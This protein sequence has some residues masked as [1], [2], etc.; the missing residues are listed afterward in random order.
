MQSWFTFVLDGEDCRVEKE[1]THRTLSSFLVSLDSCFEHL[2]GHDSWQGGDPVILG[3]IE[4]DRHHFRVVD[5]GLILMPMLAGRQVWTPEGIQNAEPDHPVNLALQ[6]NHLECSRE[7]LGSLKVLLF[8]G[9]YRPDLRRLGQSND[10]F[11]CLVTR[12]TNAP[13]IRESAAQVFESTVQ[14]RHE[15]AQKAERS[16]DESSVWTGR[17]DIFEDRFSR[18]LF[19][20]SERPA[21]NYVD[22]EKRR[23]YRPGTLVELL[24]LKR[25]YPEARFIAG[26][27]DV[28]SQDELAE[29]PNL[30]SLESVP[31]LT[32]FATTE[33]AW[34]I[35]SA[36]PLTEIGELIGRE[37]PPFLK[38]L[39][40]FASRPIRNRATLG[41][42]LASSWTNGQLTPL[43]LAMNARV[44]LLSDN[45]ERDA[46]LSQFFDEN[47]ETILA[48]DEVIRSIILPRFTDSVLG[49]RG[50]TSALIDSYTVAPR[51]TL[52]RPYATAA[53]SL[54]F[55]DRTIAK[56]RIAY[57]G[58]SE[59]PVRVREAEE[60]LAGKTWNEK[61]AFE[62]LPILNESV[63]VAEGTDPARDHM[64]DASYR[65]QLV[66]T[67][68]QK[69][70]SQHPR[71]DSRLPENLSANEDF[72]RLDQPFF[73]VIEG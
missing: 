9:Y 36:L 49:D 33:E 58:I 44:L 40:R 68:F 47:G 24:R 46:P 25:E 29:W 61:T 39:R 42:Y 67:L 43:L 19:Q 14:L 41:G 22:K 15:A 70:Y 16:G 13:A 31:E 3:D 28:G 21:I 73:D 56:A 50:I 5:A 6:N 59:V 27:T 20:L 54:E 1:D 66:V 37:C 35:G 57:S 4:G 2:D 65:R 45:G 55:R 63:P 62:T 38:L 26:G 60:F 34:E 64:A 23:F 18:Q 72:V 52:C 51:R 11:D 12:T 53:F 7:R 71:P 10:Q 69:F 32:S 8:E 48:P 30:I 17:R